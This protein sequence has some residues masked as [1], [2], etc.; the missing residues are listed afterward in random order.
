MDNYKKLKKENRELQLAIKE[1]KILNEVATAIS[2]IQSIDEII[3]QIVMKCIKHLDV[4]EGTVSLLKSNS[5]E[6]EFKTMVRH[7]NTVSSGVPFRLDSGLKGWMLKNRT[8]FISNDIKNDDRFQFLSDESYP[9]DSILAVP[10]IVQGEMIGYLAVFNKRDAN[11]TE[12]DRRLLSI[13]GI[14]SAQIIENARLHEEEKALLQLREEIKLAGEIQRRLLPDQMPN[15]AKYQIFATNIPAKYV[16]GDYYDFLSLSENRLAFCIGDITG[17]GMPAAMLMSN[18]QAT[19]R[20]QVLVDEECDTCL[21]RTNTLLFRSTESTKF[22][23]FLYGVLDPDSG[24]VKY[25]NAGHN[26]P[27]LFREKNKPKALE[28]TGVLLGGF[29]DSTY[30]QEEI[31]LKNDDLLLLY[32]DGVTE[33]M[34]SEDELY[35]E[36]RLMNLVANNRSHS[37]DDICELV[38]NDV[39]QFA[40][41]AIQ[42]DDI[43]LVLIKRE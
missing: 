27:I 29:E 32:S 12:E 36:E 8:S 37:V 2:S 42:S 13:I 25:A 6:L 17:K 22:A 41:D 38:L 16:G 43:T 26:P 11:F 35:G 10:L 9:F 33:A 23:T 21:N 7:K 20:S 3:D 14:Q 31:G 1:L 24:K 5:E 18:L 4:Q 39:K 28:V 19:F 30:S 15:I 40:G 34:N